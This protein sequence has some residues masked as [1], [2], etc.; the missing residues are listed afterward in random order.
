MVRCIRGL[1]VLV[2]IVGACGNDDASTT[3]PPSSPRS[4]DPT[5]YDSACTSVAD[6]M[7][8]D[9][10]K[11]CASCCDSA[12]VRRDAAKA[13]YDAVVKE[14]AESSVLCT[15]ACLPQSLGCVDGKCALT[16]E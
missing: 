3:P 15:Q 12:A 4:F 10:V 8:V 14:C 1:V 6:C 13:D 2:A 5:R 11:D 9:A 16:A 7:I